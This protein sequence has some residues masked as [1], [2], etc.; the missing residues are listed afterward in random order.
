M[1]K[2]TLNQNFIDT[3]TLQTGATKCDYFDTRT[4]GLVMQILKSGRKT[5][6]LRYQDR[7][8]KTIQRKIGSAD[9]LKLTQARD[10]ATK[11][12]AQIAMGNDPF[13]EKA[14]LKLTPRLSE[15]ISDL[16]LPF[17]QS[18]KR[19]W[20]DDE[21]LIKNHIT[22]NF[23]DLYM[24]ELSKQ[25]LVQFINGK[26]STH[27]PASINRVLVLLRYIYNLAIKWET[28]NVT[29]NPIKDVPLLNENT[30]KERYLSSEE[31]Q[32]LIQSLKNSDN[33]MLQYIIPM[34]IFTGARK[35]EVLYSRWEDLNYEQ[36]I[37]RIPMSKS[38]KARTVPISDAVMRL[39]STVP[40]IN[41]CPWIFPNPETQ[42]PYKNFFNAWHTARKKV[43]LSDV[44]V[45]DLRHS[46]ASFLVNSGR[47]LYEVQKILGHSQIST[48]QR[49]AH[50]SNASLISAANVVESAIPMSSKPKV[51]ETLLLQST[52]YPTTLYLGR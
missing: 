35:N 33:Q 29:K 25:H 39:L 15:F 24:D 38:G 11:S 52:L 18:Y 41:D 36:R 48:T 7:R 44:R 26:K 23:G 30:R 20:K 1:P 10:I 5:Y 49:Y 13:A 14:S 17:A 16:Y 42:R 31:A 50:L 45:H 8:G 6:Y 9:V 21:G 12:L 32:R 47:S 2:V 4:T 34:L 28:T 19:S 22:P 46:F 37:W 27:A 3:A 43:G 51:N 40:K